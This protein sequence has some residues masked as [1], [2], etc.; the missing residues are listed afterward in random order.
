MDEQHN[1]VGGGR[2]YA[3]VACLVVEFMKLPKLQSL[4]ICD[5]RFNH[6]SVFLMFAIPLCFVK[7]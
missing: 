2:M 1:D 7:F 3:G 5:F 4:N 6:P